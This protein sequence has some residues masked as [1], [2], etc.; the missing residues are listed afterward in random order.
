MEKDSDPIIRK[1]ISLRESLWREIEA[2]QRREA[3]ATLAE[4]I[5]RLLS[6]ALRAARRRARE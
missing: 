2:F 5:R 1:T 4:A 6:E 3:T